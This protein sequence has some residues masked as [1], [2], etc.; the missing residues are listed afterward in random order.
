MHI[1]CQST[2]QE[3]R[4]T[5]NLAPANLHHDIHEGHFDVVAFAADPGVRL[6]DKEVISRPVKAQEAAI[7]L[8]QRTPVTGFIRL[9]EARD[10]EP[11]TSRL[12]R[13]FIP[14][15]PQAVAKIIRV[16]RRPRL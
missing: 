13:V 5:I 16:T 11:P 12:S 7:S 10:K 6:Q 1:R 8:L 2:Q 15:A 14:A 3:C 9:M 4:F